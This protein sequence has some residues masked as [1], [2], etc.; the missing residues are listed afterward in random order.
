MQRRKALRERETLKEHV[1][2]D[3]DPVL[4]AFA[5]VSAEGNRSLREAVRKFTRVTLQ[6]LTAKFWR[7]FE[8]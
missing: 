3:G 5:C 8:G 2:G 7:F 6:R 1:A 4:V